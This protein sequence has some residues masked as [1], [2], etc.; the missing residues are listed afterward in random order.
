MN[1]YKVIVPVPVE[2]M[3][4]YK[5]NLNIPSGCRVLVSFKKQILIGVIPWIGW[6]PFVVA[7]EKGFFKDEGLDVKVVVFSNPWFQ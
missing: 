5:S 7:E 3:F 6:T 4:V 2:G 1:Y